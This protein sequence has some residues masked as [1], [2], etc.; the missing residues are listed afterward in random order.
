MKQKFLTYGIIEN[1]DKKS[2]RVPQGSS[3]PHNDLVKLRETVRDLVIEKAE[4]YRMENNVKVSDLN[5]IEICCR[6]PTD[7]TKKAI[8][9]SYKITRNFLAKFSVGLKL[10]LKTANTLFRTHSGELNLT[11][12]FDFVVHYALLSKDE[13]DDFIEEVYMLLGINL[14][15]D[16]I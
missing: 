4:D 6:I 8:N 5:I 10:D 2:Y 16:K 7:T 3:F 11:N 1:H 9:G 12:G 15:R 14:D 13:I